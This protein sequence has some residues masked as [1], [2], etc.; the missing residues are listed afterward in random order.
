VQ[1]RTAAL[2]PPTLVASWGTP[3]G[4]VI[5]VLEPDPTVTDGFRVRG[6]PTALAAPVLSWTA[7]G[8]TQI[9]FTDGADVWVHDTTAG[10]ATPNPRP[11]TS[12]G[13]TMAQIGRLICGLT[14]PVPSRYR[15][16]A[17]AQ[18]GPTPTGQIAVSYE[19]GG[20]DWVVRFDPTSALSTARKALVGPL[21]S[22]LAL[23]PVPETGTPTDWRVLAATGSALQRIDS[24][25]S[26]GFCGTTMAPAAALSLD[27]D[28]LAPVPSFGGLV[29]PLGAGAA[30]AIT[31]SGDL[32]SILVGSMT[33]PGPVSRNAAYGRVLMT[34][35]DLDD[36]SAVPAAVLEH[37]WSSVGRNGIDVGSAALLLPLAGRQ[38]PVGLGG[39]GY[40]R[41]AA[42]LRSAAGGALAYAGQVPTSGAPL[43]SA[44]VTG[45]AR[46]GC[47][48]G[49]S[50]TATRSITGGTP[51]L[52]VQGPARSGAFGPAGPQLV[53][54]ASP[55]VYL[56]SGSRLS[57]FAAIATT[58]DCLGGGGS[59]VDW[60]SCSAASSTDLGAVP[61]EVVL[62]AGDETAATRA[63]G[64]D[65]GACAD[66]PF[67]CTGPGASCRTDDAV[68]RAALCKPAQEVWLAS[69][70]A[71]PIKVTLP[72][73]PAS[74]AADPAGG[75]LMTLPCLQGSGTT[76][77]GTSPVCQGIPAP[78]ATA[79]ALVLLA[80]DGSQPSCLAVLD[81]IAGP[82]AVTPN[83]AEAWISAVGS[84]GL[85]GLTRVRLPR[86]TSD[87]AIDPTAPARSLGRQ[88][89]GR[90]ADVPAGFA[91]S[92][93]AFTPDGSIAVAT[94]PG[95]FRVVLIE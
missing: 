32:V 87:G 33:S 44:A 7:I 73:I 41:G 60:S 8:A 42:W 50:V 89:L 11:Y 65:C 21:A 12:G 26:S 2:V 36:Q 76:C 24:T 30:L 47:G 82:V 53:G 6:T 64:T 61:L 1:T 13:S 84:D 95:E 4:P 16:V 48:G 74:L 71:D 45:F 17:Y 39:S 66:G 35:A 25:G 34:L 5:P 37:A 80:E 69:P 91:A 67:A 43:S 55:P 54:P 59:S 28:P 63:L 88:V 90:A 57:T 20:N 92:G 56:A 52:M 77:L 68:C 10:A 14:Q 86:R 94:V 40:A 18:A 83:G 9:L 46:D 29:P 23:V 93:I 85:L 51:E 79:A 72:S 49:V 81:G 58:L 38:L 3:A 15:A 78:G 22:A 19:A 62:S 31:P 70:G 27:P 75:F